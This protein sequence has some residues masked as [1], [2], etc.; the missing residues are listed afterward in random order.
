MSS[1]VI[2]KTRG[3]F[4]ADVVGLLI[5]AAFMLLASFFVPSSQMPG[6]AWVLVYPVGAALSI[7]IWHHPKAPTVPKKWLLAALCSVIAAPLWLGFATLGA[8]IM[9]ADEP[10]GSKAFDLVVALI[11]APGF[12][13]VA[14]IGWI[15]ALVSRDN[16][17][18]TT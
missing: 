15:R 4:M 10:A 1:E 13:I 5:L 18:G 2:V 7:F 3:T 14:I 9:F 16:L 12:T 11:I 17:P 8:S 6:I